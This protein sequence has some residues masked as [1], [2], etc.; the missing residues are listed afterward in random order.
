MARQEELA[1]ERE[2]LEQRARMLEEERVAREKQERGER[3]LMKIEDEASK[4]AER[5]FKRAASKLAASGASGSDSRRDSSRDGL[6]AVD[7]SRMRAAM[8]AGS[9]ARSALVPSARTFVIDK[10]DDDDGY[11]EVAETTSV[12][13]GAASVRTAPKHAPPLIQG[14]LLGTES[15]CV[16]C[17][18]CVK[19][20]CIT[21]SIYGRHIY[22][23]VELRELC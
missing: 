9:T 8:L 7:S 5:A 19:R 11:E 3:K 15:R 4:K 20:P 12:A 6:D 16:H 22:S 14:L 23:V 21:T 13:S 2:R 1:R 17:N 18:Y 10:D